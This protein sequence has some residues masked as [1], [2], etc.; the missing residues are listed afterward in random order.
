MCEESK[1][2]F[3]R[4]EAEVRALFT[5]EEYSQLSEYIQRIYTYIEKEDTT[6]SKV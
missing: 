2:T 5:S 1:Q 3:Q 4:R 6:C